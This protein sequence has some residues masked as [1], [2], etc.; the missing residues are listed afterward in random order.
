MR[1][2]LKSAVVAFFLCACSIARAEL[3][4]V[5]EITVQG[6]Q[7]VSLGNVLANLSI[8][9]GDRVNDNDASKWI[10]EIY[11]TGYFYSVEIARD[12]NNLIIDLVERPAIENV[13]FSGNKTI[14]TEV[15]KNIF[16]DVGLAQGEI[17]SRSLLE[18][19]DLE[20]EKQY[21]NIGR[22]N[23]QVDTVIT[24]LTRNRVDVALDIDEGPV[25]KIKHI[26]LVGNQVFP[27]IDLADVMQMKTADS[28]AGW[29]VFSKRD[30]FANATLVGD[31][32]RLEDFYFDRGFL[33]FKVDSHQ[34]SLS[35][36]KADISLAFNLTEGEPYVISGF[37]IVGDLK[38]LSDEVNELVTLQPGVIY[39]RSD[40]SAI[41]RNM[42]DLLGEHGYAYAQVRDFNQTDPETLQ[43]NVIFQ[44]QLGSPV[45]VNRIIIQG[46]SATND[47]VIRRELRQ[48]EKALVINRNIRISKARLERL[49]YFKTVSID[50]QRINGSNDLADLIVSVE[51]GKDSQINI[52]G[53]YSAGTGFFGAFSVK[54]SNFMGSG[55]DF[56]TSLTIDSNTQNYEI[57]IEN[58]Y[59]TLDGVSLGADLYYKKTDYETTSFSSYALNTLGGRVRVGYPLSEN[60]R[61]TYGLGVSR[62]DLFLD[63]ETSTL[64]MT[65]FRDTFG[66]SYDILTAQ[67]GWSFNTLNGT[68][69]ANDGASVTANVEVATPLG[70]LSYYRTKLAAQKYFNFTDDYAFRVHTDLGYGAGFGENNNLPFYQN[71]YSGGPSSVRGFGYGSL[72]P[73]G[74]MADPA[75]TT[76]PIGGNIKIEYGAELLIPTPLI[77]D[78][79]A[80]RTSLF[81]DAGNVFT[82]Y[83]YDGSSTCVNGIDLTEMR[84][85]AGVD[86]TW[87]TAIA[88]LSFSYAWPL[89]AQDGDQVRNFSFNIGVSF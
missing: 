79:S 12:K 72:G 60:Q 23:A 58:P 52:S 1:F 43:V 84:Y 82:E 54:Q 70:D 78:Q 89:N 27:D 11:K 76:R 57:S 69:K 44:V 83:C 87:I 73:L 71:Y 59:F 34:I 30:E 51:E 65:D 62:D 50:V 3:F 17:F 15:L 9:E 80:F 31:I 7:R 6:L 32:Q 28:I 86:L 5:D 56:S 35:E 45:Y 33:D 36:D 16:T 41:V 25:A 19:I 81:L 13:D 24:P 29:K 39:S 40:V 67:M 8:R 14:Q 47:E 21:G 38:H 55:V 46:N 18:N 37:E 66:S 4:V 49:G 77:S 61:V 74:T 88:P 64:E 42:T 75:A 85:S 10:H 26:E 2:I 63:D 20:L 53:G 68:I 22:Y 48:L